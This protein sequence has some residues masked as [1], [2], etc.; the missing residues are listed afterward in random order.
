MVKKLNIFF[1]ILLGCSLSFSQSA[2]NCKK[3]VSLLIKLIEKYHINPPV[4]NDTFSEKVFV[5]FISELDPDHLYF[6]TNDIKLLEKYKFILADE[7]RGERWE[8]VNFIKP[9]YMGRLKQCDSLI[10]SILSSIIDL[11]KK[12]SLQLDNRLLFSLED[13]KEN[14]IDYVKKWLKYLVLDQMIEWNEKND[15]LSGND[16]FHFDSEQNASKRVLHIEVKKINK[17]LNYPG[18][19]DNYLSTQYLNAIVS[20]ADPHSQ[21]M[22]LRDK[23][24]FEKTLRSE[25]M[26]FGIQAK[27]N[28]NHEIEIAGLVPGGP[29]W[30]SNAFHKGDIIISLKLPDKSKI[31]VTGLDMDEIGEIL[32]S[33]E[34][35]KIGFTVRK[36]DG[37]I[38]TITLVREKLLQD[39]NIVKSFVLNGKPK[40]GYIS[41]P[42]FYTEFENQSMLGCAND[43]AKECI[44]LEK[45]NIQGL[46]I[47]LRYNGGGSVKEA[48]DLAGIFIDYGPICTIKEKDKNPVIMKDFNRGTIYD[49]PLVILVN[50]ESASASE[51]FAAAMQD[52]K[53]AVI[54][55]SKTFGKATGQIILP[56]DNDFNNTN[57][58]NG[59]L[60]LTVE[61]I[62]RITGQSI[63]QKGIIPDIILPDILEAFPLSESNEL[64]PLSNDTLY[65]KIV[66]TPLPALPVKILK[67]KSLFRI[68]HNSEFNTIQH[69]SDTLHTLAYSN[70][71]EIPIDNQGFLQYI[72]HKKKL[73]NNIEDCSYKSQSEFVVETDKFDKALVSINSDNINTY[74]EMVG[75]DIYIKEAYDVLT[76]MVNYK[77]Q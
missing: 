75:K 34:N 72:L 5:R 6:T 9:M 54:V 63:Q 7:F 14:H 2:I 29:A 30:K 23:N 49:G 57:S 39:E 1:F 48:I 18:S 41:L 58:D 3:E 51:I 33:P 16:L 22:T 31:I 19:I 24:M 28:N 66:F 38:K 26:S 76:D 50:K 64:F 21:Y 8:F 53:R 52:Y 73:A 40:I 65:K 60:K 15:L 35:A 32:L 46:I 36:K 27:E 77:K 74:S 4:I 17:I 56:C 61:K 47:D 44:K 70:S 12:E 11:N 69:L 68:S 62:Y 37:S 55:G 10:N 42:G 45:E 43:V 67:E 59:F 20:C 13:Y 71:I 25:N